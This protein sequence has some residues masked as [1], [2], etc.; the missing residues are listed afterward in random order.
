MK[1]VDKGTQEINP[2]MCPLMRLLVI[3]RKLAK[4]FNKHFNKLNVTQSQVS[5]LLMIAKMGEI[6]QNAIGKYLEL[7]R[8]TVS[9]DLERL[10]DKGYINKT[11][12]GVSPTV[13]LTKEGIKLSDIVAHEWEKWYDDS[14]ELLGKKGMKAVAE[15]EKVMIK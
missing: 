9:R 12:N 4:L 6:S 10:I 1:Q 2:Q 5:I 15:I 7:E 14:C 3:S 13:S 11:A 8:S